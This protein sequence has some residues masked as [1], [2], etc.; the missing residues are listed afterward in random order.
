MWE[1]YRDRLVSAFSGKPWPSVVP[2]AWLTGDRIVDVTLLPLFWSVVIVLA[3]R[4]LVYTIFE[5]SG[6]AVMT[7]RMKKSDDKWDS[8]KQLEFLRKW[9]ESCW[10]CFVYVFFT[11]FGF[12]GVAFEPY[13]TDPH[14]F[15]DGATALPLNYYMP[16]KHN[17]FYQM[18]IGF[19][20]Q[21]IPFLMFIEVRRKDW[22]ESFVHHIVTLGLQ[23][24][25]FYANFTRA[26]MM[27]MLI[28]DVSDIFLE[29]AKLCRY[30]ARQTLA[31][32]WFLGF[33][34]SWII[35]RVIIFPRSIVFNC[36][37]DPVE[38]VAIPYDIDPQPHFSAF[39]TLFLVLYFLHIY[40]T[41]LIL[42]VIWRQL[43]G[44][45][46]ADVREEDDD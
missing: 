42:Q 38:L 34:V 25:S 19:Y 23:Y 6:M 15:W 30:A 18:Q 7:R 14:R 9:N 11:I 40:W 26:G 36:L 45:E 28:H 35:L 39:A 31:T 24:Y 21:A 2:G 1:A 3:R 4:L 22:L 29:A 41:Y 33:A 16:L 46:A 37:T 17:L 32:A 12:L 5:P 20:L 27:V 43:K 13:F 8:A 10:K 44:G